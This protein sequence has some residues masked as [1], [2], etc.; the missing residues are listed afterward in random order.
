MLQKISRIISYIFYPLFIPFYSFLILLNDNGYYSRRIP[1]KGKLI[2]EGILLVMTVLLPLISCLFLWKKKMIRSIFLET[3]EER[4]YPLIIVAIFYYT[5]YYLLKGI[6]VSAVYSYFMLGTTFLVICALVISF[7]HKISLYM[8][9]LGS[10]LG[11]LFG[12]T[13]GHGADLTSLIM[14]VLFI[15]GIIATA[16]LAEKSHKPSEIYSGLLTG[17]IIMFLLFYFV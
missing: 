2:L 8:I 10:L 13:L 4:I 17:F 9:S 3:R 12:L 14:I 16:R 5:S 15:T 11:V 1:L 6:H 7:F